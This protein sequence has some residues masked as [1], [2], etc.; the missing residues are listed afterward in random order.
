MNPY[1]LDALLFLRE[2]RKYWNIDTIQEMLDK[3]QNENEE[4]KGDH[5]IYNEAVDSDDDEDDDSWIVDENLLQYH[6]RDDDKES[7]E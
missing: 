4:K 1:H 7:I 5:Q 2:N 3:N 6:E